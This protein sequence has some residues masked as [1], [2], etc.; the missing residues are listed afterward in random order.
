MDLIV[1]VP[2][3]KASF[4]KRLF[5]E[6]NLPCQVLKDNLPKATKPQ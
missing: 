4:I 1:T 3:G 6:F 5:R 2:N